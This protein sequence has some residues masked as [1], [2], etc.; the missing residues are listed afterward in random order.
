LHHFRIVLQ[1]MSLLGIAIAAV[2][3]LAALVCGRTA[4]RLVY[5]PVYASHLDLLLML[6]GISG[7]TA[8]ASFL[9]YG[10][11]AARRFREQLPVAVASVVTCA[12]SAYVLTPRYGLMGAAAAILLSGLAQIAGS[13][14][15]LRA[16]LHHA[17]A[18]SIPT[19]RIV[20]TSAGGPLTA[21]STGAPE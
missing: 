7:V 6:V 17:T 5:G 15:V 13:I 9:G 19:Q 18:S 10:M 1:R 11:S 8:V 12:I 4:L 2:G 21:L 3:I 16:A 20:P 14:F